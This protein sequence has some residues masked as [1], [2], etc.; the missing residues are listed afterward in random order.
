[1]SS[2][3]R[4]ARERIAVI[5]VTAAGGAV[6][7]TLATEA[8]I[9]ARA[10]EGAVGPIGAGHLATAARAVSAASRLAPAR[11]HAITAVAFR[12]ALALPSQS[13]D[14][15][16]AA[17]RVALGLPAAAL[18][19]AGPAAGLFTNAGV[20]AGRVTL[21]A[22]LTSLVAMRRCLAAEAA[23]GVVTRGVAVAGAAAGVAALVLKTVRIAA[24]LAT[25]FGDL[26]LPLI[27]RA[28][29]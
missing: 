4:A 15:H 16:G 1:M 19:A 6:G 27:T 12:A 23:A 2:W 13:F 5:V 8:A 10:G 22:R 26:P 9:S 11:V 17:A 3:P 21:S 14:T 24:Q 28:E 25:L 29:R 18:R 7:P 20:F